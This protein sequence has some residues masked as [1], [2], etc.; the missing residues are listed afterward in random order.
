MTDVELRPCRFQ[1]LGEVGEIE[2]AAFPDDAYNKSVFLYFLA[3]ARQGFIVATYGEQIVGYVIA[4]RQEG[5]G[6]IQ[7][8]AV[9]EGVR[10]QGIGETLMRAAIDH[11][12]DNVERVYLL[13]DAK[14]DDTVKFYRKLGFSDT[15][16]VFRR[17]YPNGDDALEMMRELSGKKPG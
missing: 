4:A 17:Y 2:K 16:R 15:S 13:V 10:R 7:S 14:H 5:Q 8:I 12:A 1:D 6:M 11:L 3:V 9:A